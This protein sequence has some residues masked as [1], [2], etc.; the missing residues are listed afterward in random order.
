MQWY[1]DLITITATAFLLKLASGLISGPIRTACNLRRESLARIA[2]FQSLRLPLPRE[3]AITAR[4]I[5]EY[6]QAVQNLRYA[7]RVFAGLGAQFLSLRERE[8]TVCNLM[9]MA[10]LDIAV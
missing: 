2:A 1:I 6:D 9:K 7:Q 3:F 5:R 10:S 4:E 8:P